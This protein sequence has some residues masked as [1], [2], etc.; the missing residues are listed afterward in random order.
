MAKNEKTTDSKS[1]RQHV[2]QCN[3]RAFHIVVV[4]GTERRDTAAKAGIEKCAVS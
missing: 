4:F 2:N 3:S 1:V